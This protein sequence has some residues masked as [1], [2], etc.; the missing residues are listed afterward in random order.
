[1]DV[2]MRR[3]HRVADAALDLD[4]E[5][6]RMQKFRAA[7]WRTFGERQDRGRDRAARMD[8]GL[9]MSIVEVEYVRADAV[10]QRGVQYIQPL[11]PPEHARLRSTGKFRERRQRTLDGFVP[12]T[13]DGAAD[14]IQK[15]SQ[16]LAPCGVGNVGPT[17]IDDVLREFFGDVHGHLVYGSKI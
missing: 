11:A 8:D 13:A 5:D 15:R 17:R 7:D 1:A 9:E 6:K 3:I 12:A 2:V 14:P 16:R 4:A 10:D